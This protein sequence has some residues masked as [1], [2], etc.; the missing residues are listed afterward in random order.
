MIIFGSWFVCQFTT[1]YFFVCGC[2]VNVSVFFAVLTPKWHQILCAWHHF[3]SFPFHP[4]SLRVNDFDLYV[5]VDTVD[6]RNPA[7]P[8]MYKTLQIM[9][10]DKPPINWCRI[11]AINSMIMS[12]MLSV[13]IPITWIRCFGS[14]V[15]SASLN[16]NHPIPMGRKVP[17]Q[18]ANALKKEGQTFPTLGFPMMFSMLFFKG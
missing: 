15:V 7:P 1:N 14:L 8:G 4:S 16:L 9:R 5:V 17:P 2:V 6:G 10:N 11:S 13:T 3:R 18:F 12:T